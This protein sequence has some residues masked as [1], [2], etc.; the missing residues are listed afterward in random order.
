MG[1]R[2]PLLHRLIPLPHHLP[3]HPPVGQ[4]QPPLPM[5]QSLAPLRPLPWQVQQ[6]APHQPPMHHP[7]WRA[8]PPPAPRS[9]TSRPSS[10]M[11]GAAS[12]AAFPPSPP[13]PLRPGAAACNML[14]TADMMPAPPALA[15]PAA[16]RKKVVMLLCVAAAAAATLAGRR[17][18]TGASCCCCAREGPG[19][20]AC[21]WPPAPELP[22]KDDVPEVD[23]AALGS[24]AQGGPDQSHELS[25]VLHSW[26][27]P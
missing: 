5:G 11:A 25:P 2:L 14:D 16:P 20:A 8:L 18:Q 6:L 3:L 12:A 22:L 1:Q 23:D 4:T 9:P 15:P 21:C 26:Q 17:P 27:L 13:P 7:A 24:L 10:I 19:L